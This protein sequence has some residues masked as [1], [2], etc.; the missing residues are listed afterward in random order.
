MPG[1][2]EG[3]TEDRTHPAGA[4]NADHQGMRTPSGARQ[5]AHFK[6]QSSR[7]GV[8]VDRNYAPT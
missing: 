7:K 8:P 1:G 5:S 6:I 2:L 4:D 3:G